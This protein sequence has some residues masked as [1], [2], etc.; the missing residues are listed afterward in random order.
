MTEFT[1]RVSDCYTVIKGITR[2]PKTKNKGQKTEREIKDNIWYYQ[3]KSLT[4]LSWYCLFTNNSILFINS[5]I[6]VD[7]FSITV[8]LEL[9]HSLNA[10]VILFEWNLR[11]IWQQTHPIST[12]IG[13]SMWKIT[14]NTNHGVILYIPTWSDDYT[15]AKQDNFL[16]SIFATLPERFLILQIS[17]L[18]EMLTKSPCPGWRFYFWDNSRWT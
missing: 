9:S 14:G 3:Q 1:I 8:M 18:T 6:E 13:T 16:P 17:H 12:G 5:S 15:I 4:I 2:Y 7:R 10:T 11:K